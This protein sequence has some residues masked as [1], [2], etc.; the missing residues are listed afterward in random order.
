MLKRRTVLKKSPSTLKRN[1]TLKRKPKTVE[2]LQEQSEQHEKDWVFYNEVWNEREHVCQSC[3][4]RLY[5][6]LKN[7]Y[8]EHLIEKSPYPEFRYVKE[9][10]AIVCDVCHTRKTNGNPTERH[11]VLIEQAKK[12]LLNNEL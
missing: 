6:E 9:N 12:L 10:I 3:D 7:Y 1:S 4:K 2:Q 5:G 11:K 8:I